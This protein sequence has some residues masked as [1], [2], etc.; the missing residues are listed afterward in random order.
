MVVGGVHPSGIY[1]PYSKG[2][3]SD[4]TVAAVGS[5][6]CATGHDGV[7]EWEGT[8]FGEPLFQCKYYRL[9]MTLDVA[10]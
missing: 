1:A 10:N 5:V 6:F 7:S 2:F 8:S 3:A 9:L 4:L